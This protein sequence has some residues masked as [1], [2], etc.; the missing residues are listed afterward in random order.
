MSMWKNIV[1]K[2]EIIFSRFLGWIWW[3]KWSVGLK[4]CFSGKIICLGKCSKLY[5]WFRIKKL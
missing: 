4:N 5:F 3:W 2:E 1:G